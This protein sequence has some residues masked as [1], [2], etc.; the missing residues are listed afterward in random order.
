MN[1][2]S[3]DETIFVSIASFRDSQ[4]IDTLKNLYNNSDNP[5]NIYCGIFTQIDIK[6][7][8]ELCYDMNFPYNSNIRRIIIKYEEAKGPLWARVKIIKNLYQNEKYFFMIDAH[9]NFKKGWDTNLKKYLN[10]LK[11]KGVEKPI[12]SNYPAP[13][14]NNNTDNSFVLCNVISGDKYPKVLQAET[15]D[16]GYFYQSYFIGA[17]CIFTYGNFLKEIK[18]NT[19][20]ENLEYIFGGEEMLLSLLAFVNGWDIYSIPHS[21]IYHDYKSSD[22]KIKDKTDWYTYSNINKQSEIDSYKQLDKILTSNMLDNKRK[23][24]D[25][26][27]KIKYKLHEKDFN[28]RFTNSSKNHLCNEMKIIKL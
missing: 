9:T 4:C 10:T 23:V 1:Y 18:I 6:N 14:N 28:S 15:K 19:L 12:L 22:K 2:L 16:P 13:Y 8:N 11:E 26:Y 5:Q 17:N 24:S 20:A 3:I 21:I 25:F 7:K 27:K